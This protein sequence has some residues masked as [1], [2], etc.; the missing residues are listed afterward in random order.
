[1][2]DESALAGTRQGHLVELVEAAGLTGAEEG[3]LSS[4]RKYD[5]FDS[6]WEPFTRGVGPAG[7][8][9]A[10]LAP[11]QHV[12]LR[13]RCRR[14]LPDGPFVLTAHAWAARGLV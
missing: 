5:G 2:D 7:A 8:F 3:V 4:E 12:D 6:W 13:E 14:M 10:R 9:L 11:E 1:V